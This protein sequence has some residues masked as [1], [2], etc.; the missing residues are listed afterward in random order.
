MKAEIHFW[1]DDNGEIKGHA[2]GKVL[3]LSMLIDAFA[4]RGETQLKTVIMGIGA[5]LSEL[6]HAEKKLSAAIDQFILSETST[7][8]LRAYYSRKY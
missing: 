4:R 8:T 5:R 2:E 6:G 1:I 3:D 7:E